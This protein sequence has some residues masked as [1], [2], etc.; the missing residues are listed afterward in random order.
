M[1]ICIFITSK[2]TKTI[3]LVAQVKKLV[4]KNAL[5]VIFLKLS[6]RYISHDSESDKNAA[7]SQY[8]TIAVNVV[9]S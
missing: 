8:F 6:D 2:R 4:M 1:Y 9:V 3:R 5:M 7:S